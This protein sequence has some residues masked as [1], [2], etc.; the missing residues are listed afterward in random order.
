MRAPYRLDHDRSVRQRMTPPKDLLAWFLREFRDEMPTVLHSGGVWRDQTSSSEQQVGIKAVGGSQLGT[1]RTNEGFRRFLEES[2]Q[3]T[4][5]AEYEG[6][7]DTENTYSFP[8]RA[9][10]SELAGRGKDTEPYPFMARCLYVTALRDGDWDGAL[11]SLGVNPPAVRRA[12]LEAALR[13]LWTKYQPGP[14][15]YSMAA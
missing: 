15:T 13:R 4:E 7:K 5:V 2:A 12:Y 6:H 10:L 14:R 3:I 9:A 11:A 1:P 8:I